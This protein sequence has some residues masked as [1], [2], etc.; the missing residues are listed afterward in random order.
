MRMLR[1]TWSLCVSVLRYVCYLCVTCLIIFIVIDR[2]SLVLFDHR[3]SIVEQQFAPQDL[4]KSYPYI[5]FKG[6]PHAKAWKKYSQKTGVTDNILN[7]IGYPADA[8]SMPK[9][10]DE[11]RIIVLGGSTVFMGNPEIPRLIQYQ[12]EKAGCQRVKVYNFGVVSSVSSMELAR[13]IYEAV[14]YQPDLMISYS[15]FN[16]ID[17][18]FTADPRPGYPFNY[19]IYE[20]NPILESD[21]RR[22]PIWPLIL[23]GS[24]IF[25]RWM[26][27]Y[28]LKHFLALDEIRSRVNDRS[29]EWRQE[30]A[31]IYIRNLMKSQKISR[32]FGADFMAF[33]QP[34]LYFKDIVHPEEEKYLDAER[35]ENSRIIRAHIR[36]FAQQEI[37][38]GE[39]QFIDLSDFFDTYSEPVFNDRVHLIHFYRPPVSVKIYQHIQKFIQAQGDIPPHLTSCF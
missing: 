26:P 7:E 39:L 6:A 8:P 5:M 12:F 11:F 37:A 38:A 10:A 4:R 9:P 14:D 36:E 17:Q 34:A 31:R 18:P 35:A 3:R 23:Y 21:I 19:F 29:P 32:A 1:M 15:G 20:S 27:Q 28:F 16:D 25:R 33:F 2:I 24:N 13:I 30:I 22:Y